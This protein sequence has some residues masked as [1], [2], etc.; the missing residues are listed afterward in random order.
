MINA[1]FYMKFLFFI[2][3]FLNFLIPVSASTILE[4][5]K[6]YQKNWHLSES[7]RQRLADDIYHYHNAE[8]MWDIIRSEFTLPHY[9]KNFLVQEQ[10][11]WFLNNQNYLMRTAARAAPYLYFIS[12]QVRKRHL[13][14]EV[15]L[16]PIMESA[17]NPFNY[18]SR[19]AAGIWQLMP[20]TA[21]GFGVKQNEW[22]DG[23]KDVIVS[24]KA[25]LDYLAYLGNFFDGNWLLAIAAYD[26]GQGNVLNAI[27]KNNRHGLNTS[28]WAL[29]LAQETRIYVPRLLAL[30][31][32][33]AH[34]EI[35]KI[36]FPLIPNAPYLAQIDVGKQM[37]LTHTAYLAG[38]SLKDLK[39]LN[40]G[41]NQSLTDPN[42]PHKI[43]LPI[44]NVIRFSENF[45]QYP[46]PK[47]I[48]KHVIYL[49]K[50]NSQLKLKK[51]LENMQ[52]HYSL[53]PGDTLYMVRTGDTLQKVAKRFHISVQTLQAANNHTSNFAIQYGEHLIIPTH[54][55][56]AK[57][58]L[59][60]EDHIYVVR[61]GDTLDKIASKFH[62]PAPLI[63]VTN[64][65]ANNTINIG[66]HLII[67]R[68]G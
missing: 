59:N 56:I 40:P 6:V 46:P 60:S 66:D 15:A 3:I 12:E 23:R 41:F 68:E 45:M 64:L 10:I 9:E 2:F 67:P 29:P 24:T 57:Y 42:G 50:N 62:T 44:E 16:I 14:L 63:R 21:S 37:E 33:I 52:H 49:A 65:L 43:I 27:R 51:A 34:P 8:N 25:A 48:N 19:G 58:K 13:P 4:G 54:T 55:H 39:K 35:Y 5:I 28:F 17:F 32:I 38:L 18:S 1:S 61:A 26:T 22:Y 36:E 30:A 53:Q 31:E 47:I 7:F 20:E 11:N